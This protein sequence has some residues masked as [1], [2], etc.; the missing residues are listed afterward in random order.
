[1]HVHVGN[2]YRN[3]LAAERLPQGVGVVSLA[4][5][6]VAFSGMA[7]RLRGQRVS[8]EEQR[9]FRSA[10][11]HAVDTARHLTVAERVD[12]QNTLSTAF[13]GLPRDTSSLQVRADFLRQV[14]F[15]STLI[16]PVR[17]A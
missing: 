11:A 5:L 7:T 14:T 2:I 9:A 3:V 6:A 1:M 15:H 4:Q 16:P 13:D 10:I 12:V 8:A 17:P